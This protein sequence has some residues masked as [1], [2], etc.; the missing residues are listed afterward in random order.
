VV[1]RIFLFHGDNTQ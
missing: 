1:E